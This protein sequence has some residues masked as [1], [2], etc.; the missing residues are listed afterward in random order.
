MLITL[1][2]TLLKQ[3]IFTLYN[4]TQVYVLFFYYKLFKITFQ[5]LD[6]VLDKTLRTITS[7]C[8]TAKKPST[9]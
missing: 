8:F 1:W 5:P 4:Y 3:Y 6:Y 7:G 2:I 9:I